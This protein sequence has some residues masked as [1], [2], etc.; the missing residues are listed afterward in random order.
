MEVKSFTVNPF[1]ENTLVC[2]DGGAAAIIDPGSSTQ[3]ERA[4]IVRFLEERQLEPTHLLLTHGHIDH[5]FDCRFF[6]DT[7]A[8]DIWM[9][10]A[11]VPLLSAAVDQ[12]RLYGV[13][14]EKP[15]APERLI[16]ESDE[17][18]VGS[19][20]WRILHC[21][22][23]SPGSV[24]FYDEENGFIVGGDVLFQGSIGRTDLWKG[25]MPDLISSI[26]NKLLVLDDAIVVY[27]G[28][29]GVTTIGDERRSNPFLA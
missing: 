25:S 13:D 4:S 29:G 24:C 20:T 12:G 23:H 8:L 26:R 10:E 18:A 16:G 6:A 27:P 21:P 19:A 7:Y 15:P 17:I 5:I 11:D 22:G 2:Y 14:V 28:H 3:A 1:A 9:H